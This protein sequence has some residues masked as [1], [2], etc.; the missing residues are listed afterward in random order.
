MG[1]IIDLTTATATEED[2][3]EDMTTQHPSIID[4]GLH[5]DFSQSL[6]N[7]EMQHLDFAVPDSR[8]PSPLHSQQSHHAP[9]CLSFDINQAAW[10]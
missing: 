4:D 6:E 8:A 10:G 5:P 9:C 1:D 7:D 3:V 2:D